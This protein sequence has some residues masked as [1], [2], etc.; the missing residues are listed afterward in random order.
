MYLTSH[1]IQPPVT[2]RFSYRPPQILENYSGKENY[3]AAVAIDEQLLSVS[4]NGVFLPVQKVDFGWLL[5]RINIDRESILLPVP[6][7]DCPC[8]DRVQCPVA[9]WYCANSKQH[10]V[11]PC[12]RSQPNRRPV[13]YSTITST[14][15]CWKTGPKRN[16]MCFWFDNICKSYEDYLP[17]TNSVQTCCFTFGC[18]A[19]TDGISCY[20][21]QMFWGTWSLWLTGRIKCC[22]RFPFRNFGKTCSMQL[23]LI[24]LRWKQ[25]FSL[26]GNHFFMVYRKR[27][28]CQWKIAVIYGKH[29]AKWCISNKEEG[30]IHHI[31]RKAVSVVSGVFWIRPRTKCQTVELVHWYGSAKD[32]VW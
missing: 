20:S 1:Q 14:W 21:R 2:T 24:K 6:N 13:V 30:V 22:F 9:I 19:Y 26:T 16:R 4:N 8:M 3:P 25:Y 23:S 5:C 15:H 28:S 32:G 11:S 17:K 12:S 18:Y 27:Y 29:C 7:A 10:W 31:S